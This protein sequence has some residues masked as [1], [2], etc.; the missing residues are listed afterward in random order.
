MRTLTYYVAVSLDG[1]IAGPA[2]EFDAFLA[3][4]DHMQAIGEQFRGTVPTVLAEAVGIPIQDGPFDTVLMGWNTYAV[5]MPDQHLASP[6]AHLRQ[7]VFT[8]RRQGPEGSQDVLF[9]DRDPVQLVRELKKEDGK[10]IWLCGGG[11]LAA[12]LA[13]EIDQLAL[14][15][16]PVTFGGGIRLFGDRSYQPQPWRSTSVQAFE[17]GVALAQYERA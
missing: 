1:F 13:E 16:N 12:A 6:Y 9:T 14:K 7:V 10:D 15:I 4:G 3:E 11:S 2:G 17:S 5:G 8:H